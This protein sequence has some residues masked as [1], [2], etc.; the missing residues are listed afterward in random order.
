M[1]QQQRQDGRN[2]DETKN[3]VS[4][5]LT[6]P[7]IVSLSLPP[8]SVVDIISQAPSLLVPNLALSICLMQIHYQP[9][10]QHPEPRSF[11]YARHG[12][13]NSEWWTTDREFVCLYLATSMELPQQ[14]PPR[15]ASV[16][17]HNQGSKTALC[18]ADEFGICFSSLYFCNYQTLWIQ[19]HVLQSFLLCQMSPS[20]RF[21]L[22]TVSTIAF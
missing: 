20:I 3:V 18:Y 22:W 21:I 4:L 7:Q 6:A 8:L 10:S 19:I 16:C 15:E 13:M 12:R 17:I 11:G 9:L 2:R 14:V 1:R 5:Y